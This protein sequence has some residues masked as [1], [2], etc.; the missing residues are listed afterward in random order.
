M[1]S[2]HLSDAATPG[3]LGLL[4]PPQ[5][6]TGA[7]NDTPSCVL[8]ESRLEVLPGNP[9][10]LPGGGGLP[11]RGAGDPSSGP[12]LGTAARGKNMAGSP[13][14]GAAVTCSFLTGCPLP[15]W[16]CQS[17]E[18]WPCHRREMTSWGVLKRR[19]RSAPACL[20]P[21]PSWKGRQESPAGCLGTSLC[22]LLHGVPLAPC[23]SQKRPLDKY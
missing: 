12:S 14:L 15:G 3:S 11:G 17:L 23:E 7:V 10:G 4:R 13:R 19:P 20:T 22:L 2:G 6:R 1:V 21:S 18:A 5:A 16:L 8:G 9:R